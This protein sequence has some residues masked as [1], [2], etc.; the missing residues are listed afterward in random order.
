M[1]KP[2]PTIEQKLAQL[3]AANVTAARII[4]ADPA[5]YGGIMQEWAQMVLRDAA[6][7]RAA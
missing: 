1:S 7:E 2:G 3:A 5:R 4:L 6:E